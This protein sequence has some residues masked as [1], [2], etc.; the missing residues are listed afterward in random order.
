MPVQRGW[1][2][3]FA[4]M[5]AAAVEAL[6]FMFLREQRAQAAL[7]VNAA[8][9]GGLLKLCGEM[10]RFVIGTLSGRRARS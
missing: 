1:I 8:A 2:P 7:A 3:A 6:S 4:G 5:T 10:V 9:A